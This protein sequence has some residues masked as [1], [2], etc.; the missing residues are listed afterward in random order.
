MDK[1]NQ[2]KTYKNEREIWDEDECKRMTRRL[3]K[4]G[5]G[6]P[7]PE[8]GMVPWVKCG[9]IRYNGGCTRQG[10]WYEAEEFF[11]PKLAE[12]F[13]WVYR[14]TWCWTI[15]ETE[16]EMRRLEIERLSKEIEEL[17]RK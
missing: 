11:L 17:K 2:L 4:D 13:I 12:G 10:E 8:R 6:T 14:P 3:A 9:V 16:K 15:V 1:G 5:M 7:Y